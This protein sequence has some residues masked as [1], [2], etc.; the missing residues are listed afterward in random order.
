VLFTANSDPLHDYREMWKSDGTVAGTV[1]VPLPA[2]LD[3]YLAIGLFAVRG[4]TLYFAGAEVATGLELWKLEGGVASLV[5][6]ILPGPD[7]SIA[8]FVGFRS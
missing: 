3:P 4:N 7:S 8:P 5:K 1:Q 2:T 6:D